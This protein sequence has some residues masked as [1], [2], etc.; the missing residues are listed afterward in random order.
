MP[1]HWEFRPETVVEKTHVRAQPVDEDQAQERGLGL[2]E[3]E[4][5][6]E[7]HQGADHLGAAR[8]RLTSTATRGCARRST[9]RRNANMPNDTIDRAIK[10]GTGDLEGV[11]YEEF[12]YEIF[13]PGG[14]RGA[15]RDHDRQ[16]QPDRGR[17]PQRDHPPRR[18]PGRLRL[19]RLHVQEAGA[20]GLRQDRRRRGQAD[21][22]GDRARAPRTSA[23]R[24]TRW[25]WSPS[26]RSS[27]G[28][29]RR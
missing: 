21:R 2:E 9:R 22:A 7:G 27:S 24:G 8:R 1:W 6:D 28:S 17:D 18:Q 19:G 16:P 4:G 20:G 13:G 5:L 11:V 3:V 10:K 23:P 15:G 14:H 25:W 29:A 12:N 26:P